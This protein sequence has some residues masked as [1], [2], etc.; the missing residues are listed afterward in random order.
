MPDEKPKKP[1]LLGTFVIASIAYI[2]LGIFMVVKSE[3]FAEVINVIF[4]VA[5]LL[6]GIINVIAFFLNHDNTENLFMELALGVIAIGLGI[7]SL[8]TSRDIA[9]I[10]FYA[11]GGVL[12][13]DGLVNVKR[14]FNLKGIGFP[15]WN[16][17]LILAVIGIVLGVLCIVL[18]GFFEKAVIIL[19]GISLIF[20][21]VVSLVTI[22]IDSR[23]HKRMLRDLARIE[24]DRPLD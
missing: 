13:I 4:G 22:I 7:F 19:F 16:M 10:L 17:L 2:V 14:A 18:Y 23:A 5:M 11:I 1:N 24:R 6:Y 21:G 8:V 15:R 3:S 20:E 12:I 9:R